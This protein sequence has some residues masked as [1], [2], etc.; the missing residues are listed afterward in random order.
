MRY[1]FFKREI[2]LFLISI[3]A[4]LTLSCNEKDR[5][6]NATDIPSEPHQD[7]TAMNI[8]EPDAQFLK[9]A[10]DVN[11]EEI[12]LGELAQKNTTTPEIIALG[13][14]MFDEHTKSLMEV[15]ELAEKKHISLPNETNPTAEG[16]YQKLVDK[17]NHDFDKNYTDLMVT[18]HKQT[19]DKFENES[20]KG[21]DDDI[22]KWAAATLPVLNI[23]LSHSITSKEKCESMK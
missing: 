5:M 2:A 7:A 14:M 20:R 13:K 21:Q 11:M 17:K 16:D 4:M 8:N 12:K 19:I 3:M 9:E 23:H 1:L 6:V 10:A 22:K 18:G 15:K